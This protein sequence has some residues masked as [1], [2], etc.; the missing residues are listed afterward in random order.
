MNLKCPIVKFDVDDDEY[1][2]KHVLAP[3]WPF[4]LLICG[5]TGSGKTKWIHIIQVQEW[6][7]IIFWI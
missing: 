6:A 3:Q 1:L 5:Q 4:R 2:N 7:K